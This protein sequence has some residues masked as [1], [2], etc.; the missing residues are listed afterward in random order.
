MELK[1]TVKSKL[2]SV[3]FPDSIVS[4]HSQNGVKQILK[5][6]FHIPDEEIKEEFILNKKKLWQLKQ[7]HP[8]MKNWSTFD[9]STFVWR[10]WRKYFDISNK[11]PSSDEEPSDEINQLKTGFWVVRAGSNGDEEK[12]ILENNVVTIGW[13]AG[14]LSRFNEKE[15]LKKE[16]ERLNPTYK[17]HS[18][19]VIS[20]EIW[21]FAKEIK[22]GDIAILPQ[23]VK[24]SKHNIAIAQVTDDYR[25]R[26]DL[27]RIE[28]TR[29][30]IWL[31]KDIPINEFTD[32]TKE[33][34]GRPRR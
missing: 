8:I 14:N 5:L 6:L 10:V 23:L 21:N 19:E 31:H 33:S 2:L 7:N 11:L 32:D 12:D 17:K 27:P 1:S 29:P 20:S 22:K 24:D 3:Y 34:F 28:N 25:Y 30:V 15:S 16:F 26:E 4:I 18:I 13:G 9:Y